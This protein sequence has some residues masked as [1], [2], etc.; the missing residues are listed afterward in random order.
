MTIDGVKKSQVNISQ[1][2]TGMERTQIEGDEKL[3][4]IFDTLDTNNNGILEENELKQLD[5]NKDNN[6]NI[7]K[8]EA[9]NFIKQNNLKNTDV[10]K[11]D[12]IN[13]L[14]Q[15]DQWTEN[16][17]NAVVNEQ[18]GSITITYEDDSVK[19]INLNNT[20]EIATKGENGETIIKKFDKNKKLTS[21]EITNN[22]DSKETTKYDENGI[23]IETVIE[24]KDDSKTTRTYNSNGEPLQEVTIE[25]GGNP[26]KT[27]TFNGGLFLLR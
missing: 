26:I 25:N 3:E 6:N 21:A 8:K 17:A 5:Q 12:I 22:D 16:I 27:V 13:F 9:Q 2:K 11:Q 1:I 19:T 24:K 4:S 7:T 14:K 18:D 15:Y 23:P 10:K 20:S